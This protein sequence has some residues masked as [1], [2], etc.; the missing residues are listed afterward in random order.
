MRARGACTIA[1]TVKALSLDTHT[2]T[3]TRTLSTFL[4]VLTHTHAHT[5]F[6]SYRNVTPNNTLTHI[7][8]TKK[9]LTHA[10]TRKKG[11]GDVVPP[12]TTETPCLHMQTKFIDMRHRPFFLSMILPTSLPFSPSLFPSH[13]FSPFSINI[14]SLHFLACLYP[15][16]YVTLIF[17]FSTFYQYLDLNTIYYFFLS[18]RFFIFI[19]VFILHSAII[20]L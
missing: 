2:H 14:I 5:H 11:V 17:Y 19:H 15:V 7:F 13:S 12:P 10:H 6:F 9:L 4:H 20:I 1:A 16:H 18:I 3:H 8:S